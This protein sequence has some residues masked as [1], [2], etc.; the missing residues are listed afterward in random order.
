ME[1][2]WASGSSE[3]LCIPCGRTR[4][5][6]HIF[7]WQSGV[8]VPMLGTRCPECASITVAGAEL[9]FEADDA[10]IDGYLQSEGGIDAILANLYR[11]EAP[12]NARFLD[13][14][15]NYGFGVR[16]ARDVLG[17]RAVGVEPSYAGRRGARELGI[18]VLDQYVTAETMLD[19]RYDVILA[20]EVIEHVPD[21]VAF[22][23]ALRLHLAPGGTLVLTTPAAE[24]VAP[25]T[26]VQGMQAVGPGGH[27]FLF[28]AEGLEAF[29]HCEGFASVSVVR[30]GQSLYATAA[31]EAGRALNAVATGPAPAQVSEFLA[32]LVKDPT[33]PPVLK[34][35]MAVRHYRSVV[36]L[37][38]DAP[39]LELATFARVAEQHGVDLRHPRAVTAALPGL[40]QVP[41]LVAPAAFAGGM[42]RVVHRHDWAEAVDYFTLAET[43]VAEKR[44][45]SHTFD[46]DSRLIESQSR[47]HRLL[48][49]LHTE[50]ARAVAEWQ[51]LLQAGQLI[52]PASWT[53]RLF[54]EASAFGLHSLFD[55]AL[56]PIADA[57]VELGADGGEAHAVAAIDAA[58]LLARAAA[59][60]GDRW[61]ATQWISA[62][63]NV[64]QA[65]ADVLSAEWMS[66][67]RGLHAAVRTELAELRPEAIPSVVPMPGPEHEAILWANAET[68]IVP[69]AVSV[70]M[71]LY[72]GEAYVREALESVA[73]QTLAPLEVIVVDD[74]SPDD[75]VELIES[76]AL[77]VELRIVRQSN[78]GQSAA[79]NAGIRAARGEY[80]AFLDQDDAWRPD[81]LAVLVETI[82]TDAALAWVY[83][84]FDLIDDDG[85]TLVRSYL[86]E[87]KVLLDRRTVA[88][89]VRTDI[90]ALPSASI[91]RRSALVAARGFDRRLSGYEDDELC[92]RL[93]RAGWAVAPQLR[94]RARY[95]THG[96]NASASVAFLRSRLIFLQLLID[97]YPSTAAGGTTPAAEV[98]ADRLLRSTTAEYFAALVAHRD[99]LARTIAW[100]IERRVPLSSAVSSYHR[101]GLGLMRRPRRMRAAMRMAG[102]MPGPLR[103]R[104]VPPM[105][106]QAREQLW[107]RSRGPAVFD[108]SDRPDWVRNH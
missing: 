84:D 90:M 108:L 51:R 13:V 75:S 65:R 22:A 42:R 35:A 69:G 18:E 23:T 57:I 16:F 68:D 70:I 25:E 39:D 104:L 46:G 107:R 80:I 85:S 64:L 53:V 9:Q 99:W 106:L 20:S 62:A 14:G 59:G 77:P 31:I 3:A 21:P 17:W 2:T 66:V 73:A 41:L 91:M 56:A 71:A 7:E 74:G 32:A 82:E 92:I 102:V 60:H 11:V 44:R 26:H 19:D 48:A 67:A 83:G 95:R 105:A 5:A 4:T 24:V 61:C 76:L 58:Y 52:D 78:A 43:A 6:E 87:T 94:T 97:Y 27:L 36:N 40:E 86:T 79:R 45:R 63:E 37:G 10:F 89:L 49:L 81:H 98:A 72:R 88:D 28:T 15:A 12:A 33:S 47:A 103:R 100:A 30:D 55:D 50:P 34:T 29:L 54:V 8:G 101:M 1:F 96:A 93:V 38:Q